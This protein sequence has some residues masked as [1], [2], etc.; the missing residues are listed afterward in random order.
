M[1]RH[2]IYELF[3][4][5][6][7]CAATHNFKWVKIKVRYHSGQRVNASVGDATTVFVTAG[8]NFTTKKLY[9]GENIY[10]LPDAQGQWRQ[11]L[12]MFYPL[13]ATNYQALQSKTMYNRISCLLA[14]FASACVIAQRRVTWNILCLCFH[15]WWLCDWPWTCNS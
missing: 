3:S 1:F 15:A 12:F 9:I 14:T 2:N 5:T 7:S 10:F 11:S 6:W 4:P 13:I 8:K